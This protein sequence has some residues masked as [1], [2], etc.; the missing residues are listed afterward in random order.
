MLQQPGMLGRSFISRQRRQVGED[1]VFGRNRQ[2]H[3][4][5]R[6]VMHG[7]RQRAVHVEYPV[8][9][10][11]QAHA[12]SLRWRIKPSWVTEATSCPA[13]LNTLP[14]EKPRE[15]PAHGLSMA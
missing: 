3:A 12:Q 14:R 9:N 4:D 10:L 5:R 6:E 2:G 7:N 13:R 11:G 1:V 15:F 8:T